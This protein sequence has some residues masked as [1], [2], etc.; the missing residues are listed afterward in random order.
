MS[1][2]SAGGDNFLSRERGQR[3]VRLV[4]AHR[5][6]IATRIITL[7]NRGEQKKKHLS[8][9]KTLYLD[10]NGLQQEKTTLRSSAVRPEEESESIKTITL[11]F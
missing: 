7:Y 8:M 10:V 4:S 11:T 6:I 9:H 2:S 5:K 3:T 1:D